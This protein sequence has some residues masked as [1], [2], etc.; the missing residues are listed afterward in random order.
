[1]QARG[2]VDECVAERGEVGRGGVDQSKNGGIGGIG[3][4]QTVGCVGA[5][6]A[7]VAVWLSKSGVGTTCNTRSRQWLAGGFLVNRLLCEGVFAQQK[8]VTP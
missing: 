6:H 3:I 8:H 1:M 4:K 7:P 2:Q 5:Q